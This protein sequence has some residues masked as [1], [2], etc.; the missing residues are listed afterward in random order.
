[1]IASYASFTPSFKSPTLISVSSPKLQ[2]TSLAI[3]AIAGKGATSAIFAKAFSNVIGVI[4]FKNIIYGASTLNELVNADIRELII[5]CDEDVEQ[6]IKNAKK[7]GI[8][9]IIGDIDSVQTASRYGFV[10]ILVQS[11]KEAVS[12]AIREAKEA[13]EFINNQRDKIEELKA[14]FNFTHE[15]IVALDR[16]GKVKII[17]TVAEKLLGISS[18]RVIGYSAAEKIPNLP[19]YK[20]FE[21]RKSVLGEVYHSPTGL[22]VEDYFP[23]INNSEVVGAIATLQEASNIQTVEKKLRRELYFKGNTAHYTFNDL[24]TVSKSMKTLI[25]DSK[26]FARVDSTILIN[27]ETGTGKEILAQSIHNYSPRSGGP[28][29]AANCAAVPET[30]LESELF[31]YE[32]GA[33]TGAKKGGKIGLFELAHHGTLFLDEIGE[34][35][36][37]LQA[38][39]LR[40][41][42]ERAVRR[43]GGDRMIPVDVRIIAATNKDL[44]S[45]VN[46]GQ[47]REDLFY[48]LNVLTLNLYPLRERA[49]DIPH[50]SELLIQRAVEKT[51]CNPVK[52]GTSAM[53]EFKNYYWPGNVRELENLIE[54]LVVLK[55]GGVITLDDLP[56]CCNRE[57][58]NSI[59]SDLGED[60]LRDAEKG[61]LILAL[62]NC[63]WDYDKATKILKISRTTLWRKMKKYNINIEK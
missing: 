60:A 55:D 48:R 18:E 23:I 11:G 2:H 17:N 24:H 19:L 62:K 20:V 56:W 49:E 5:S 45:E 16:Y 7:E 61:V 28:F 35:P 44:L 32:E 43:V 50:L 30:L 14:L 29:V 31:G 8:G 9:V 39:L 40:V 57:L 10:S 6:V 58:S 15:G 47:F 63:G 22:I 53:E 37:N 3:S 42:Q 25:E 59:S 46:K 13:I 52:I 54:R 21:T 34:L 27:G 33:F 26:R 41:L 1:M 36:I 4:G 38:R 51:K 12:Q